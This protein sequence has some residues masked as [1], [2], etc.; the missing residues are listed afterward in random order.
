SGIRAASLGTFQFRTANQIDFHPPYMMQWGLSIDRQLTNSMGLRLSYIGNRGVQLPWAPD[1]NQPALSTTFYS[2]RPLTDRPFPH[3]DLIYSRDAGANSIYTSL[4]AEVNRRFSSGL[5]FSSAYTL[6]KNLADNAGPNPSSFAGETGG[7]RVTDS[8]NR[9]GDRGDVYATR[10]HRSVTTLY[11]DLPFGAG[12]RFMS[13][14]NRA[15]DA[16]LGAWPLYSILTL[17]SGPYLP[18]TMSGGDPSGTNGP[19]RGTG[20]PDRIGDGSVSDPN[21]NLWLD[22][23]AFLCPGRTT[24][25]NQFNCS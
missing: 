11:Y 5:S 1:L 4:Q 14:T 23:N 12:R 24:G 22:R 21:R 9:R 19:S 13:K 8:N 18:P 7:G 17:Q 15:V 20:R 25:A 10:R 3:W 6:A 16:V 2:Q